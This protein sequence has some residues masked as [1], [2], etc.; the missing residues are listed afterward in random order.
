LQFQNNREN[1]FLL[2]LIA[3]QGTK[4]AEIKCKLF[5]SDINGKLIVSNERFSSSFP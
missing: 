3:V 4:K 1:G 5:R 2:V